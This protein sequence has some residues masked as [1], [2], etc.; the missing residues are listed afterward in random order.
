VKLEELKKRMKGVTVVLLTP[1]KP[2]GSMDLEGMRSNVRWL[3]ERVVGKDFIFTPVGST[4]EFYAM[5]SEE[6]K[7]VIKMVVEE[8]K[9]RVP[10]IAGAARAG[11]Y[12]TVEMCK[13][14][15]SVGAD[16]V[17]LVLPY[18]HVPMEEGMYIHYKTV[19]ES[20]GKDFGVVIYNNPDVSGSWIKPPLMQKLSKIQNIIGC[21]E[22]TR[23]IAGYYAQSR[24]VK[25]EDMA[26]LCGIGE[27]MF[28]FEALYGCPGFISTIPNFAPDISYDV[29]QAAA[30]RD[31]DKL[32]KLIDF[33][34]PYRAFISKVTKNHGPHTGIPGADTNQGYMYIAVAKSAMDIIGLNGREVR[35]PLIGLTKE[36]K[37]ELK[38][39][40]KTIKVI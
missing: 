19:A 10:V 3:A 1:F 6:C 38:E 17:Q 11:T 24:A 36:E 14:A 27:L 32:T 26:I 8:T 33:L 4:G 22:N 21:K 18:Y 37:I 9:G 16:G 31:F 34:A 20:V 29:Y 5:S 13:Y 2:D 25:P 12:N 35:L 40:L 7:E 23:D 28:S 15:E 39:V 30:S